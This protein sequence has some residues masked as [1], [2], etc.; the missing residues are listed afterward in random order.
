MDLLLER[1]QSVIRQLRKGEP[2][3]D[4][5][6][7]FNEIVLFL[8]HTIHNETDGLHILSV[9]CYEMA[10]FTTL[11]F[12]ND[13]E[14]INHKFFLILN[15]TFQM[16]FT[17]LTF[18]SLTK[19]DEQCIDGI[20]LLIRNLCL[21]KNKI[22]T[23]FYIDNNEKLNPDNKEIFKLLS[24]EKIF[25]TE[26]FIKKFVRLIENDIV[27]NNYESYHIKYKIIDRLL[28]V[29]IK[30]NDIDKRLIL[31]SIVK[32][33]ES[34][35]YTNL[36]KTIN[37]SQ[38]ILNP[39]QSFFMYTCPK[40]IRLCSYKRQDDI[41]N[42]LSKSII[43]YH[44]DIF[45]KYSSSVSESEVTLNQSIAWYVELLNHIAL[46]P[47]TREFFIRKFDAGR[48]VIDQVINILKEKS[49][50][51]SVNE[52]IELFHPDVALMSYSITVLYNL[53]FEKK[54]FHDLKDKKVIDICKPLY[55]ARDKTIQ[56][57]ARTLAAILNK[58]DID[59]INNPSI[60][61]RSYLYLIENTIDDVTL[62]YHGI[63][64]DGV[65]TNLEAIVQN[66]DVKEEIVNDD[67]GIP[68]LA[69]CAYEKNL[70]IETIQIPALRIIDAV[71]FVND[72]AVKQIKENDDLMDHVKDLSN[73]NDKYQRAIAKR[74][75]W[76][77]KKEV[78][79]M[80]KQ[81]KQ[82]KQNQIKIKKIFD[83]KQA[84][85]QYVRGD[86]HFNLTDHKT[87][88]KFDL[89]I[90]YYPDDKEICLKIYNRLIASDFYR[91][92][93]NKDN[94]HSS[95]PRIMA[96]AIE[97]SSIILMCFSSKYRNS[98]ACRLEA[99]YAKKRERPIIPVKIDHQYDPTGWLEKIIDNEKY[100][101]FT[102]YEFNIMFAQLIDEINE[103]KYLII[104][105]NIKDFVLLLS[106]HSSY[107]LRKTK[108][109]MA[110]KNT[111]L[112]TTTSSKQTSTMS[113]PV[114]IQ[115]SVKTIQSQEQ[116]IVKTTSIKYPQ[117][118]IENYIIIWL[119][120]NLDFS[121]EENEKLINQ[122]RSIVNTIE[123][124]TDINQCI[125]FLEQI[126]NEKVF[127][128]ISD[129]F[130]KEIASFEEKFTQLNS[131]YIFCNRILKSNEIIQAYK[132]GKGIFTQMKLLCNEL[133]KEIHQ[134]NHDLLPISIISTSSSTNL[135]ELDPS[136]T[137]CFISFE[138]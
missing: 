128:I 21:Y 87:S 24:Y 52:N 66:D 82:K 106:L 59:K 1:H 69:R 58:E 80:S 61:A 57:A 18:V 124:L 27:I 48:T 105:L 49:L 91:I 132:K 43:K 7:L 11:N 70:D 102:K 23:N 15:K 86:H 89:M 77:V 39:Q 68:L 10:R 3:K 118:I 97:K 26:L 4:V 136:F 120:P 32:C 38:H 34:K 6:E 45:E 67:D 13:L 65:L 99:E 16:L 110:Q 81:E 104:D 31:D 44:D 79:F 33:L 72:S 113:K 101:D 116:S 14:I 55:K 133:K 119:D 95:N 73:N 22:S 111:K 85:Y 35:I 62:T 134:L 76:K 9:I 109:T 93:F 74:I 36:Y 56:F 19:Q 83:E 108:Y 135:N 98:Y 20:S 64:L 2:S 130:I 84:V 96:E 41:S 123:T 60:I 47:T 112:S 63:K 28:H 90:S 46:T 115:S 8:N 25:F 127:L 126:K 50:I 138:A 78:E 51:K 37:L 129:C 5:K 117:D 131:I 71:S 54:I 114:N 53:T 75:L 122:L 29:F 100:I 42:V 137:G 125:K 107:F 121:K 103:K 17:K 30:L 94:L 12:F 88:E 92:L 40:F